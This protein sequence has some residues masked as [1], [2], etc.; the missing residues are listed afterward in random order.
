MRKTLLLLISLFVLAVMA[1]CNDDVEPEDWEIEFE[2]E[3]EY[4]ELVEQNIDDNI[5]AS[6][7]IA[8]ANQLTYEDFWYD[9]EFLLQN[10]E[11][12]FPFFGVIE[13]RLRLSNPLEMFRNHGLPE[14][15][16]TLHLT[17]PG[18]IRTGFGMFGNIAHLDLNPP[19][20]WR[21][22]WTPSSPAPHIS[23]Y[24]SN[25]LPLA[26]HFI[27]PPLQTHSRIIEEGRIALIMTPPDFFNSHVISPQAARELRDFIGE[28]QGYE[29]IIIDFR[30]IR[31]GWYTSFKNTFIRPNISE[32]LSF[33]EFAFITDGERAQQTYRNMSVAI[34]RDTDSFV[35]NVV[36]GSIM[37]AELFAEQHNLI[38]MN[39]D[40]LENLAYGFLLETFAQPCSLRLPLLADNIW[41]LTGRRNYSAAA[42]SARLAKEAGFILV[43]QEAGTRSSWGR[44]HFPLPRTGHNIGMDLFYITDDTG[45]NTEE[46]PVEPH[47]FNRA[48]LDALDT[49]LAIIAERSE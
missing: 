8:Q 11:E 17:F 44:V 37:P 14:D 1:A 25:T 16:D 38:N 49:V 33:Y 35:Q 24:A 28:I 18:R 48:P 15:A 21:R 27:N 7:P 26:R 45:R 10:L 42:I 41:L 12:N 29:H 22:P 46:F 23:D 9:F 39:T 30:H 6:I 43:G 40:D 31:G 36:D 2:V 20:H 4:T 3:Q 19:W 34:P 32:P 47:Y 5:D 13:R